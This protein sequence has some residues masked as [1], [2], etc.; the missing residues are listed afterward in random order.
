[1]KKY[2]FNTVLGA[3]L[4]ILSVLLAGLS[5]NFWVME[6]KFDANLAFGLVG[7]FLVALVFGYMLLL[8]GLKETRIMQELEEQELERKADLAQTAQYLM[9]EYH[10]GLVKAKELD[11]WAQEQGFVNYQD[12]MS[13]LY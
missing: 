2:S 8:D 7:I 12:L 9:D 3:M 4:L 10:I 11:K 6:D 5:V 1:M 13:Y